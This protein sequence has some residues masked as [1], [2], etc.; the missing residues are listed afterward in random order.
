MLISLLVGLSIVSTARADECGDVCALISGACSHKG[1]YCKNGNAC[2]DL[3]WLT[4]NTQLCNH[5]VSGCSSDKA[6][7]L[8]SEARF[9]I[10]TVNA[11]GVTAG[12]SDGSTAAAAAVVATRTTTTTTRRPPVVTRETARRPTE[13]ASAPL[14]SGAG[15][16]KIK[17]LGAT[18]YLGSVLQILLHSVSVRAA[19]AASPAVAASGAHARVYNDFVAL[20]N[21]MYDESS[22]DVLDPHN[23]LRALRAFNEDKGF[24]YN[25]ADDAYQ[26]AMVLL[27]ALSRGSPR[28][29][30][31][32]EIVFGGMR[33]CL[34]CDN[35]GPHFDRSH[36][37]LMQI[38][39]P[40][41]RTSLEEMI[42]AH[43]GPRSMDV[44]CRN[45]RV[46]DAHHYVIPS[47]IQVPHLLII[48]I[49][50]Y[51]YDAEKLTT[52]VEIPLAITLETNT[53]PV[54]Y[55][56]VGVVAHNKG[57]YTSDYYNVD[58]DSWVHTDDSR[59]HIMK[60]SPVRSGPQ[61]SI[62]MYER[63]NE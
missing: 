28:L 53:G 47:V 31:V 8:C 38:P 29:A 23:I 10:D 36:I 37:Q 14:I 45:C 57:H 6:P 1:S 16:K 22:S 25:A 21:Q 52:S 17:N 27:N 7:L 46:H 41:R 61:P 30:R 44:Q 9:L 39:D 26:S 18:C 40:S 3:F 4:P 56:L 20:L 11:G 63:I 49:N 13:A 62:V 33:T 50:R 54:M 32:F 34:Q 59:V 5:S 35:I 51:T 2:H 48:A 55:R 15:I 19:V 12:S 60:G 58:A 42:A 24:V 43:F